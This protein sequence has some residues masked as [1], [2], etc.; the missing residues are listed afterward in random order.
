MSQYTIKDLMARL[1]LSKDVVRAAIR[2]GDLH[3]LRVGSRIVID[4]AEA[5]A[6]I[7]F[8]DSQR[9][10]APDPNRPRGSYCAS[11]PG[12]RCI[13]RCHLI[14]DGMRRIGPK[15]VRKDAWLPKHDTAIKALVESAMTPD[16]VAVALTDR[17]HIARTGESVRRRMVKLGLSSRE[18]WVSGE[19][20]V[21]TLGLY[22]RRLQQFEASGLLQGTS[23]GAWRRYPLAMVEELIRAQAGLTIDP[24]RIKNPAWK[25]LAEVSAV[26]NRRSA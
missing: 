26:A 1:G 17:F 19:D 2:R 20:L 12:G 22:R 11:A 8:I 3:T 23:W 4:P 25:S 18:G 9:E 6:F 5:E 16:Q 24:R 10:A 14:S 15:A 21:R 7:L 13:C